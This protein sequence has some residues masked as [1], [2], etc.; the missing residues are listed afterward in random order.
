MVDGKPKWVPLVGF[1]PQH[2]IDSGPGG[3]HF[4]KIHEVL[5]GKKT[6]AI[7]NAEMILTCQM[8]WSSWENVLLLLKPAKHTVQILQGYLA[9]LQVNLEIVQEAADNL[10]EFPPALETYIKLNEVGWV[11]LQQ[12]AEEFEAGAHKGFEAT[13]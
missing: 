11:K 4:H 12:H 1:V 5:N 8:L 9:Q 7:R 13:D 6:E 3:A 2:I 10:Q